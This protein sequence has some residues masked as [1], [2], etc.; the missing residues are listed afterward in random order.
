MSGGVSCYGGWAAMDCSHRQDAE[1]AL[2][3]CAENLHNLPTLG[4]EHPN[5]APSLC[6]E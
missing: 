3:R 2:L 6:T 4:G 5:L 1:Q